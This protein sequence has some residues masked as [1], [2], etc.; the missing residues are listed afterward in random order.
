MFLTRHLLRTMSTTATAKIVTIDIVSDT[1]CPWYDSQLNV[2][3]LSV[4]SITYCSFDHRCFIGKRRLEKAI[5]QTKETHPDTKFEIAW[6]PY[7]LDPTLPKESVDKTERYQKK[8][9]EARIKQMFP[10]MEKIGVSEFMRRL[11]FF[12]TTISEPLTLTLL[13]LQSL[14]QAK[15]RTLPSTL[16][17][18]PAIL[19]TRTA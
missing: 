10:H 1:V 13:S 16:A 2:N 7:E 8:F 15:A 19:L 9:G 14:P 11:T 6:H 3:C 5:V 18:A 4:R 12:A 17:A